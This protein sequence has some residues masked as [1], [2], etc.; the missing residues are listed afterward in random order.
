MTEKDQIGKML[1]FKKDFSNNSC[2]DRLN[3]NKGG[4]PTYFLVKRNMFFFQEEWS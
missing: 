2:S 1:N 3:I 4:N